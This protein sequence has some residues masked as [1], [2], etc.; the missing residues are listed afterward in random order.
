MI[1]DESLLELLGYLKARGYRFIAVT[2]ETHARVLARPFSGQPDLRDIFGWNRPFSAM[3]V[4]PQLLAL[5]QRSALV[6][7]VDGTFRSLIRV[8]SLDDHLF[9]HSSFPTLAADAVFFGPDTYRFARFI[10]GELGTMGQPAWLV[11]MGAGSGAGGVVAAGR[12]RPARVSLIDVNAAAIRLAGLN[13]R[14]AGIAA[15]VTAGAHLPNGC[16][17]VIANPPYMIDPAHRTYRDGG[18]TFGGEVAYNWACEALVAL[19]PCG[20]LLLYTGAAVVGGK[21]PL[22]DRI[23][24]RADEAGAEL[25][26]DEIDPDVFGNELERPEYKEVER[27]AALGIKITKG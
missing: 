21:I 26:V 14:F 13:C 7:E 3:D 18:N 4:A 23:R 5:L 15:E 17:V 2:P 9:L 1:G 11:D 22:L 25:Q 6:E 20:T 19:A 27:I 10:C 24:S 8:A 12:A 16:D